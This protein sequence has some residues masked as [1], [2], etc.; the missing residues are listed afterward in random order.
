MSARAAA[1]ADAPVHA[2]A[3]DLDAMV[4]RLH[5]PTVRRLHGELATRAEAEGMSYHAFLETLI[6]EE[7]THCAETRIRRAVRAALPDAP[8]H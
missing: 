8:L 4:L 2:S 3:K 6:A 5:P 1:P 7:I